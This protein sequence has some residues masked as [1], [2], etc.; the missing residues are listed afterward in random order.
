MNQISVIDLNIGQPY[1]GLPTRQRTA[2]TRLPANQSLTLEARIA[3]DAP[4][5][6][7]SGSH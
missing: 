3:A 5:R 2:S 6:L 1:M 7:K 4:A